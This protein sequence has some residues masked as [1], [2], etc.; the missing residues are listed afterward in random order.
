MP[1]ELARYDPH[2]RDL[3]EAETARIRHALADTAV[4]IDHVGSTSIPELDAKPII[5][6]QISVQTV[7]PMS[8]YRGQLESIGYVHISMPEPGDDVYPF[9]MKPPR[10]PSDYHVH[11]CGS[12][13]VEERRHLAFRDWLREHPEDR[14]AYSHLKHALA[15][16]VDQSNRASMFRYTDGKTEFIRTIEDRTME[17]RRDG[18]P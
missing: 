10:W 5:D 14:I 4:R 18:D 15:R 13:G 3:F 2:W 12:G 16:D 1:L 9:F 17:A 11:I 6:I 8:A 7:R